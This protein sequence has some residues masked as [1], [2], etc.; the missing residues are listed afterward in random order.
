MLNRRLKQSAFILTKNKE[1]GFTL[2]SLLVSIIITM[3]ILAFSMQILHVILTQNSSHSFQTLQFF[4]FVEDEL[5]GSQ[6]FFRDDNKLAI[7][8]E[9]NEKVTYSRYGNL[10]R[11]Q[12]NG[13]GHEI[14][15]RNIA[16]YTLEDTANNQILL[17]VETEGGQL[18]EKKFSTE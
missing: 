18:F 14:M 12:V 16:E 17:R 8:N 15:L 4:H 1:A 5:L 13:R 11:R 6:Q 3:T 9:N 2:I 7:I 10:V